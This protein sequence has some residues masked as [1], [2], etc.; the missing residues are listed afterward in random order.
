M[1]WKQLHITVFNSVAE[2]LSEFL[3]TV[4]AVAVT[5]SDAAGQAIFACDLQISPLWEK[6][7]VT[8][9]FESSVAMEKIIQLI[10]QK[11]L[12]ASFSHHIEILEDKDWVRESQNNFQPLKFGKKL[13]ICPSWQKIPEIADV[14]VSLDPGLAF[15]TG[16]HP[17]TALCLEWLEN[18][19]NPQNLVIDYGCGSGILGIAALKLGAKQV[20]AIDNDPQ[21]LAATRENGQRNQIDETMLVTALPNQLPNWQTDILI[22][23]ILAQPLIDL[24]STLASLTK[25]FGKL[26][27]SGI[28]CDQIEKVCEAYHPYFRMF[29]ANIKEEWARIEGIRKCLIFPALCYIFR[30]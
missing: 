30:Y 7:Q 1:A 28:L 2:D 25:P 12:L 16:T 14:V 29:P 11:I 24:A 13:W 26:V 27:L 18:H 19:V 21:A 9:L 23:N 5:F 8:A 3:M 17:T 22:A 15:G 10:K 4:G 20:W 6:V